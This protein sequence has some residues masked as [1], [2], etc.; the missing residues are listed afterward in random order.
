YSFQSPFGITSP[1]S[2]IVAPDHSICVVGEAGAA[3]ASG[4]FVLLHSGA[5]GRP[6]RSFGKDGV[7]VTRILAGSGATEVVRLRDGRLLVAGY[8]QNG[9]ADAPGT[10]ARVAVARYRHDGALDPTFGTGGTLVTSL[11]TAGMD[12]PEV[13]LA[14]APGGR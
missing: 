2:V 4:D 13:A 11:F 5:D 9:P 8:A 7:V 6:D 14:E 1:R 12:F 10:T 3:A